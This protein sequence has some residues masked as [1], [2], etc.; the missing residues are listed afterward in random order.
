MDVNRRTFFKTS[1]LAAAGGLATTGAGSASTSAA[2]AM[3]PGGCEPEAR[4]RKQAVDDA[5]WRN[6]YFSDRRVWGYAN[7]HSVDPGDGFKILLSTGPRLDK[8]EGQI[9]I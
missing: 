6:S 9:V 3:E 5:V 7:R 1:T 4:N 8:I 2:P